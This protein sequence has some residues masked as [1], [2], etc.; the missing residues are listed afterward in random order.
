MLNTSVPFPDQLAFWNDWHRRRGATGND[1]GHRGSRA[2]FLEALAG[3]RS[4]VVDLGCG[5]GHDVAAFTR[6]GHDAYGLDY[7]P[8]AV[9]LARRMLAEAGDVE[10]DTKIC[11]HDL[12]EGLPYPDGVFDGIFSHLA[13][14]Y[15]DEPTTLAIGQ[16]IAR[17]VRPGGLLVLVVKSVD[18]PYCGQGRAVAHHTWIR[19]GRIRRFFSEGELKELLTDWAIDRLDSFPGHYASTEVSHFLRVVARKPI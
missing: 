5:Q 4:Q 11:R 9:R 2:V 8:E 3:T 17:I 7:S 15:F 10:A 13:I 12:A 18:D 19:K 14:Q 16:E 1:P 6:A